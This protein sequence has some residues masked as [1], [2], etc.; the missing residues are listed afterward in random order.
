MSTQNEILNGWNKQIQHINNA[1]MQGDNSTAIQLAEKLVVY[2][3]VKSKELCEGEK[4]MVSRDE[5]IL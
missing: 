5:N 3:K 4:R 1:L 2:L